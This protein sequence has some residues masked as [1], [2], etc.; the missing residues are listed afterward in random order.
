MK[1]WEVLAMLGAAVLVVAAATGA[2]WLVLGGPGIGLAVLVA[3]AGSYGMVALGMWL[4]RRSIDR[5]AR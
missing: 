2:S 1:L 4:G 3:L 5:A